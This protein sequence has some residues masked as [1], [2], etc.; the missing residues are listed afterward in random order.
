MDIETTLKGGDRRS[1]GRANEVVELVLADNGKLGELFET[2][3]GDDEVV[4]MRAG[5]ALEKVC[6][7]HP[8]WLAP[9]I[10]RML[11]D[12][13]ATEQPSV[14]WHLAQMLGELD[15]SSGQRQR[16][17]DILKGNLE[18][19][20]DWI[21]LNHS[22]QVFARFV[23]HDPTLRPYFIEQLENHRQ[24]RHKSVANRASKLLSTV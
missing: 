1:L 16:A 9:Y 20:G 13:A 22:L 8:D 12:V 2:L 23:E 3:F 14:Q 11:T 10:D 5:D 7:Y 15:M 24:S 4:R 19:A 18:T 6:R 17:V 21:V